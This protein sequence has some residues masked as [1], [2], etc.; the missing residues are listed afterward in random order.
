MAPDGLIG[1]IVPS[2][3]L[4]NADA[5]HTRTREL[6][7]QFFDLVSIAELGKGA[8]GKTGTNTVV[9]FLRRKAQ[10]P[11]APEHYADR[12]ADFFEGDYES[13]EYQDDYLIKAYCEHIEVPYEEYIKL[14]AQTSLE[15]LV[16]LLQ[17]DIFN[18]Y[19]Q[20]FRTC[21]KNPN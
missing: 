3:I 2:T 7:L 1:V 15:P 12:V 13:A 6:L 4:S 17:R 18:D 5:V 11:E 16:E 14:F 9:L 10:R 20:T 8:F 19:K 21:L